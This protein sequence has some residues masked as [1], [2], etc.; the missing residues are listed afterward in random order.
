MLD[1]LAALEHAQGVGQV[2]L[3]KQKPLGGNV[4]PH[5]QLQKANGAS[6]W[7]KGTSPLKLKSLKV[8]LLQ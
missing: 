4:G 1:K 6:L 2:S 8:W 7:E 5:R 3:S